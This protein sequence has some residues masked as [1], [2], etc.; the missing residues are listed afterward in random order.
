VAKLIDV[1]YG[2]QKDYGEFRPEE[3]LNTEEKLQ[4]MDIFLNFRLFKKITIKF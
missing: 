1:N 2:P 3:T 4:M